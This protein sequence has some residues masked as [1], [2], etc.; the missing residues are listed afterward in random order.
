MERL[1]A[2]PA[3]QIAFLV[4]AVIIGG[5]RLWT[6][7]FLDDAYIT[8]Q[9]A[10]NIAEGQGFIFTERYPTWG[11][12]TPLF[13][14][15]LALFG[16]I[17]LP[18]PATAFVLDIAALILQAVFVWMIFDALGVRAWAAPAILFMQAMWSLPVSLPGMEYGLYAALCLG[19]L[20][21]VIRGAWVMAAVCAALA[22]VTRP[23]GALIWLIS[24]AAWLFHTRG[25]ARPALVIAAA[26]VLP[27][28]W[29]GFALAAF[30]RLTPQTLATR[31]FEATI[32]GSF[33]DYWQNNYFKPT[34]WV[35]IIIP[36]AAGFVL[37][38]RANRRAVWL[39][40]FFAAYTA[41]Y[42]LVGLPALSTYFCPVSLTAMAGVALA[43]VL[44]GKLILEKFPRKNALPI[45]LVYFVM[46][47]VV[48]IGTVR[49]SNFARI[50]FFKYRTLFTKLDAY[51]AIGAWLAEETPPG[52]TFAANEI[53]A[54]AWFSRRDLIEVGGLVNPDGLDLM[55]QGA[56]RE[57]VTASRPDLLI[58]PA[59]FS[60]GLFSGEAGR[61][62]L[63]AEYDI[64]LM[65]DN[66][67]GQTVG[68]WRRRDFQ[69][70]ADW[71]RRH[72]VLTQRLDLDRGKRK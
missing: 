24:A 34:E 7:D 58:L 10:R 42:S 28:L 60:A 51:R 48:L 40:I 29:Y 68:L 37:A 63:E 4:L 23:D 14:L 30:G 72:A 36:A 45:A 69:P 41:M 8:F 59:S 43:F 47:A 52:T 38:A 64:L 31:R 65:V 2:H 27:A 13:T 25:R 32:W 55:K 66:D 5:L 35:L 17:G 57:I 1:I 12:T 9:Y 3:A 18:I 26:G 6:A 39:G 15:V 71:S 50:F 70:S 54:M 20:A 33:W 21:G 61:Q 19:A 46:M 49:M 53:G 56:M 11:T 62:W 67:E 44:G 16:A 22:A